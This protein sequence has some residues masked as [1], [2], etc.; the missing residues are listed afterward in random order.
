MA[1]DAIMMG[2]ICHEISTQGTMKIEKIYQPAADEIVLL[3]RSQK[4]SLRLLINAGSNY[5]RINFTGAQSENPAKAPMFCM[6]LRK[7]LVGAKLLGAILLT[8]IIERKRRLC[9]IHNRV[10]ILR[11][12]YVKILFKMI[13]VHLFC[14]PFLFSFILPQVEGKINTY[15]LL[16]YYIYLT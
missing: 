13:C 5:P 3:L 15:A 6:L 4:E 12:S 8:G 1:F 2:A 10:T 7:H 16:S 14:L 9:N 11:K